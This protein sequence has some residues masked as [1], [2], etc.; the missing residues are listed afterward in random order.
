MLELV[1]SIVMEFEKAVSLIATLD[2]SDYSRAQNGGSPGGH[3][4]HNLDFLNSFL[5]GID[6][7]LIDYN[8][9]QRDS[10]IESDP[11]HAQLRIRESLKL[12][13]QLN[14]T[15]PPRSVRVNS[16]IKPGNWHSST[17]GRELE[18]LHSHTVHHH[19]LLREK[20]AAI[21]VEVCSDFG[22]APSTLA[23]WARR[24]DEIKSNLRRKA[25]PQN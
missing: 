22:V 9:R 12:L 19:A 4:R 20:L 3:I 16:E 5:T 15:Q 8:N 24:T 7:G 6:T 10:R 21:N 17:V 25:C 2:P 11:Q 13:V 18:F 14:E 23:Y 1:Q